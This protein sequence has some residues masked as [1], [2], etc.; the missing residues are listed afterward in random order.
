MSSLRVKLS[1]LTTRKVPALSLVFVAIVG[2]AVGVF[3]ATITVSTTNYAGG[4]KGFLHT[5]GTVLTFADNGLSAVANVPGTTNSSAS[6][7]S[8]GNKNVFSSATSFVAGHWAEA[9]Q[10][11]DSSGDTATH[12]LTINV[13]DGATAP[14][15]T[16]FS[17]S[18]VTYTVT[19]VTGSTTPTITL[20]IDLGV[21]SLN[22]PLDIYITST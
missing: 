6:F 12:I 18:P 13:S 8:T 17:F 5:S 2:M 11:T 15:G 9:I 4:E 3:A 19:G 22:T 1:R 16:A 7:L 10:I 14:S 20:Y 21:G